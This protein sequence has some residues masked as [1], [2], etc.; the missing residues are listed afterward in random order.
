MISDGWRKSAYRCILSNLSN[1]K[2]AAISDGCWRKSAYSCLLSVPESEISIWL[3]SLCPNLE[4]FTV[5][6]SGDTFALQTYHKAPSSSS[7]SLYVLHPL[8]QTHSLIITIWSQKRCPKTQL[9]QH[10]QTSLIKLPQGLASSSSTICSRYEVKACSSNARVT[11][12]CH[13]PLSHSDWVGMSQTIA[14]AVVW[15]VAF[16]VCV[17]IMQPNICTNEQND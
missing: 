17:A 12:E 10:R 3:L 14:T 6:V 15:P 2:A 1:E 9:S 13:H 7:S 8:C 4:I 5:E 11:P 16:D